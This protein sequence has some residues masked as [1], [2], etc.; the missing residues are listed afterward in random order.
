MVCSLHSF[1]VQLNVTF[2]HWVS[3][4]IC[5]LSVHMSQRWLVGKYSDV[6][7]STVCKDC[8][9]LTSTMT[10]STESNSI[11]NCSCVRDYYGPGAAAYLQ[12]IPDYCVSCP[13]GGVCLGGD[14][15]RGAHPGYWGQYSD[16]LRFTP[17][18]PPD[19]CR[20]YTGTVAADSLNFASCAKG[21][22]CTV[23]HAIISPD[24]FNRILWRSVL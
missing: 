9:R 8:P 18:I 15:P 10:A 5:M 6:F 3:T 13:T 19:A 23:V 24:G 20:G 16:P 12:N 17:C 4:C 22:E 11:F 14:L 1:Q 7:A 21:M 2:A